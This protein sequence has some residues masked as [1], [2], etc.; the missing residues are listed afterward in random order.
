MNNTECAEIFIKAIQTIADKPENLENL[1][2]YLERHF[3]TWLE[4][5]A[6][7]SEGLASEMRLFAE[8]GLNEEE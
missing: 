2:L 6:N 7:T 8:M 5:F 3:D 1:K 4:K